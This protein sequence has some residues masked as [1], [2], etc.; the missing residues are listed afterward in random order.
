MTRK[1]ILITIASALFSVIFAVVRHLAFSD[2]QPCSVG[3]G[4]AVTWWR[5][6][7]FLTTATVWVSAE[8]AGLLAI[9]LVAHLWKRLS[10]SRP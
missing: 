4:D 8:F 2:I 6:L 5:Q 3:E 1:L 9:V 7:A 10:P